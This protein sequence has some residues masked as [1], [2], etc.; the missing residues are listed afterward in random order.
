[1]TI[2]DIETFYR[3]LEEIVKK[4]EN[5]DLLDSVDPV[6]NPV[7]CPGDSARSVG[8]VKWEKD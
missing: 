6:C 1:M 7:I 2:A 8:G 3:R 5:P 4:Y